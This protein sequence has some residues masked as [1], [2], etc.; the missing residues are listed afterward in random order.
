[1]LE[2]LNVRDGVFTFNLLAMR[3]R[4]RAVMKPRV[5]MYRAESFR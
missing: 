4:S 1:M 3:V 2:N 5:V